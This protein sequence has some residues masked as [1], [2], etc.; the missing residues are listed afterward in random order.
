MSD[1]S[2]RAATGRAGI[3]TPYGEELINLMRHASNTLSKAPRAENAVGSWAV[4]AGIAVGPLWMTAALISGLL[5][6]RHSFAA[7][8]ISDL[9]IGPNAWIL[10]A[11]LIGTGLSVVAFALGFQRRSPSFSRRRLATG[12]LVTFGLCFAAAGIF[13]EPSPDGPVTI[14]GIAHFVLGF[15]V[16]MSALTV[17]LFLIASGL[18]KQP[19]WERH[20]NYTRVTA[21]LVLALILLAQL[22][23]NPGSPLFSLGVGGLMEWALFTTWSVWFMVTALALLRRGTRDVSSPARSG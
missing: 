11:S 15:F 16:A 6:E 7:Q 14:T 22:F 19:S 18:R 13:P 17:A 9:G 23:F 3:V 12:L 4:A 5:R 20:A 8:P 10:N 1:R 2:G 21:W